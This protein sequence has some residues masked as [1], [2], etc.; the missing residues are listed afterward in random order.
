LLE[1]A[2]TGQFG[3]ELDGGA[4]LAGFALFLKE[5]FDFAMFAN[6]VFYM[7]LFFFPMW[8]ICKLALI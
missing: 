7:G 2:R 5:E 3:Y 1:F 6:V 8:F 4:S